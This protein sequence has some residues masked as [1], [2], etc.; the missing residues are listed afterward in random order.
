MPVCPE[1]S[2]R[3]IKIVYRI[4]F[5]TH[6]MS[7]NFFFDRRKCD[8]INLDERNYWKS[9]QITNIFMNLRIQKFQSYCE[10]DDLLSE[11]CPEKWNIKKYFSLVKKSCE[12][13]MTL[14]FY[15][16]PGSVGNIWE[17]NFHPTVLMVN[18]IFYFAKMVIPSGSVT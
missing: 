5:Q 10:I 14:V 13:S 18:Y 15:S 1:K 6:D 3:I 2:L 12:I 7:L 17:V 11:M 8:V 9:N 16:F 4:K